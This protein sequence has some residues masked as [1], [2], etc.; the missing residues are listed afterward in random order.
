MGITS[1]HLNKIH[2]F[3]VGFLI[4]VGVIGIGFT[5]VTIRNLTTSLK[6]GA[7]ASGETQKQES[8]DIQT[9]P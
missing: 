2:R 6:Y 3:S 4:G 7:V 1:R 5:V 9:Q 8:S